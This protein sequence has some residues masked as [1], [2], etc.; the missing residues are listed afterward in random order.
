MKTFND[1]LNNI[2]NSNNKETLKNVFNH[3]KDKYPY[4]KTEIKWSQPMFINE[5]TFIIGF[6]ASKQHFSIA[7]E[8][9]SIIYFEDYLKENKIEYSKMI[10]KI[11]WGQEINFELIDMLIEHNLKEKAGYKTFWR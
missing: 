5:D 8:R 10:I 1:Y 4:L 7:P 6:N 3:I 9:A 11:K 2:E